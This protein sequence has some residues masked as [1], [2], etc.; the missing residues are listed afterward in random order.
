MAEA[1]HALFDEVPGPSPW[2]LTPDT[3]TVKGFQWKPAGQTSPA[4]GKTLLLGC[5][6][7]VAVLNFYNYVMTLDESSLL[8]WHQRRTDNAPTEPFDCS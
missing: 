3:K 8:I 6:G 2:F 4:A 5:D 7:P 1:R